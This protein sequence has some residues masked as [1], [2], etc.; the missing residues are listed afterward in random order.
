MDQVEHLHDPLIGVVD[1]DLEARPVSFVIAELAE[2]EDADVLVV[3]REVL[4]VF[5]LGGGPPVDGVVDGVAQV[6]L[7][8]AREPSGPCTGP[9]RR[10]IAG[11][12][13]AAT[14]ERW[15]AARF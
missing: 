2:A 12:R 4:P 11:R 8:G 14:V 3:E 7:T 9:S 10:D 13:P 5:E 1:P 15:P 6:S